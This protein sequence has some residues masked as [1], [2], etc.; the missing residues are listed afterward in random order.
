M[1]GLAV[2]ADLQGRIED[3]GERLAI[4][5]SA[6][7][8]ALPAAPHG[9]QSLAELLGIDKVLASRLLKALRTKDPL[10]VVHHVP[11]PEPLRRFLR[12]GRRRGADPALVRSALEAVEAFE[13][14]IRQDAGDRSSLSSFISAWL[15]EARREFE[16]RNKQS[17]FRAMSQLKGAMAETELS[18]AFLHPSAGGE[19]VDVVWLFG[20]LGLQR[21]R[22]GGAVKFATRRMGPVDAPRR[23]VNLDGVPIRDVSTARL[24]AFCENPAD[25]EAERV[26]EAMHYRL[27]DNGYGP[28]SAADIVMIE[29]NYSEMPR[30]LL[31]GRKGNVF[32]EVGTPVKRILF[33][34]L[35]HRD[36]YAGVEP[37]L[38]IYDTALDGAADI[39]DPSRDV[40]RLDLL[41]SVQSLGWGREKARH[42]RIPHYVDLLEHVFERLGWDDDRFRG[43][44]C[45]IDYPVYGSQVALAFDAGAR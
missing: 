28:G 3:V 27:A 38:F 9:P 41:E 25:I 18:V 42:A 45:E 14:L 21:L 44:R 32:A 26:G 5:L 19:H 15:P 35:V 24:D 2:G 29:V 20:L 31:P 6:V 1:S 4:T 10:A 34:V 12:A 40:D 39:N 43:Y 16:L 33:D 30:V 17:A 11:G 8:D 37:Q 22:P 13:T 36:L 7:A 23:P